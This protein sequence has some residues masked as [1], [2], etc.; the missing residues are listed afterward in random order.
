MGDRAGGAETGEADP[1]NEI[2]RD[3]LDT[4]VS[5]DRGCLFLFRIIPSSRAS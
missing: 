4:D 3:P 5:P 1:I 2:S